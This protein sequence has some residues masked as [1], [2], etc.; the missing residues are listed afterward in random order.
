[1]SGKGV[2][3]GAS[4]ATTLNHDLLIYYVPDTDRSFH[5][6]YLPTRT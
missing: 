6:A 2:V 4:I 1:M 5:T 3:L